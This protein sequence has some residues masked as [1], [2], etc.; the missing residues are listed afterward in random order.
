VP[1]QTEQE[2]NTT[3]QL[4]KLSKK[5]KK[6][7]PFFRLLVGAVSKTKKKCLKTSLEK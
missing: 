2:R 1:Q 7:S 3:L 5:K 6:I 4:E